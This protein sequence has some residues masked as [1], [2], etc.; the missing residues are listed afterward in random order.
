MRDKSWSLPSSPR[1]VREVIPSTS[2]SDTHCSLLC[3]LCPIP[4]MASLA[5]AAPF[6][7]N[8]FPP[9]NHTVLPS[10]RSLLL[11]HP[12]QLALSPPQASFPLHCRIFLRALRSHL[13]YGLFASCLFHPTIWQ[14]RRI[15]TFA[16]L[17]TADALTLRTWPGT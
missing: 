3:L 12:L 14:C 5:L 6:A 13:I 9:D 7:W 1:A 15:R 4:G 17:F 8:S 10:F 11:C 2:L 16:I